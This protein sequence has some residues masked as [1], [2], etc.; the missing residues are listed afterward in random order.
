MHRLKTK[1]EEVSRLDRIKNVDLRGRLNQ[2]RT[3]KFMQRR[4]Q[5]RKQ[6]L[7]E[8]SSRSVTSKDLSG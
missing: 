1:I 8:M 4:Q 3:S 5:N 6:R 2:E 7:K